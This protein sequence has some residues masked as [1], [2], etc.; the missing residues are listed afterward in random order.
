MN[1]KRGVSN[2]K[3]HHI[4]RSSSIN[5]KSAVAKTEIRN[6]CILILYCDNNGFD[7]MTTTMLLPP[8]SSFYTTHSMFYVMAMAMAVRKYHTLFCTNWTR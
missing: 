2:R 1:G 8:P 5:Q 3:D 6:S 7:E 4:F